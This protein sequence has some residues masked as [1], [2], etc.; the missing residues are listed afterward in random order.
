MQ[1]GLLISVVGM[2]MVFVVLIIIM[3]LM[4]GIERLFREEQEVVDGEGALSAVEWEVGSV[5]TGDGGAKSGQTRA[6]QPAGLGGVLM[7]IGVEVQAKAEDA[8]EVAAIALALAAHL[9]KRERS[10]EG[11]P[12][13]IGDVEHSVEVTD[14]WS[15]PVAVTVDGEVCWASL[16][17]KGLPVIRRGMPVIGDRAPDA[18]SGRLWRS[19]HPVGQGGYWDRRGWSKRT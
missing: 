11:R 9:S 2:G 6:H 14:P 4:M 5:A 12:I 15:S 13:V 19:A 16:D 1:E 18:Q 8:A 10:F 17:G 3:F 7:S